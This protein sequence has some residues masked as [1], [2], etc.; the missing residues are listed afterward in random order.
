MSYIIT[1]LQ[2]LK[3]YPTYQFYAKADSKSLDKI[4]DVFKICILETFKW[5]RARLNDFDNMPNEIMTP[6]PSDYTEYSENSLLSFSFS[7]GLSVDVV[8]I[9]KKGIWSFKITRQGLSS[10]TYL[11]I[12]AHMKKE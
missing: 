8:Y 12:A 4:S 10:T 6:E 7:N 2:P 1:K 5:L 11:M 9:E 3:S